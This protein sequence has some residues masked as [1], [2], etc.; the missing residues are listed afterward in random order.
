MLRLVRA[1]ALLL[2]AGTAR[3][4]DRPAV[5]V[6]DP[7]GEA[8]R[9]A[10]QRFGAVGE[11]RALAE[12]VRGE[13]V[14]GLEWSSL[15]QELSP[16]AFLAP[17]ETL[18]LDSGPA[19]ACPDWRQSGADALVE[20]EIRQ[21]AAEIEIEF[22]AWDIARCRKLL[23]KRYRGDP[24]DARRMSRSIADD[25]V[26]AFTGQRGVFG[27]EIAFV[28]TRAGAAEIFVMNADGTDL[29]PATRNRS[30]NAFPS[31]SPKGD[32]IVYMSY[33]YRR[34][35]HL[36]RLVRGPGEPG[37][38]L[39][40]L[41]SGRAQYRGVYAPDGGRLAVVLSVDG[42]PEIFTVG[43]DGGNLR[44]LTRHR[45]IDVSPTWSPDGRR[46]AFV[47]DRAGAPHVYVMDADGGNVRRLTFDGSYNA[48]PAW[49]PDGRWVAYQTRVGGQFDIW[50]IDPEGSVNAPLVTHP[51]SDESPSWSPDGR[52][53]VF[54]TVRR[55][56]SD[57]YVI[58]VTGHNLRRLTDERGADKSPAWGPYPR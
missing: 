50:L 34:Q 9:A 22:R 43:E 1:L 24:G 5:I 16:K 54:Q 35:P 4:E 45:A 47:S 42:A 57:L 46:I 39:P 37:L 36:F 26:E 25:V 20:G 48:A 31:W 27:T 10:V 56:R 3:A 18:A 41:N 11:G 32:A 58:D 6:T 51:R 30:L 44:R 13:I 49:S 7:G 2:V 12:R 21:G 15:F 53:L 23:R 55:G 19:V 40:R 38:L 8:Y 29:R 28:S 14:K 33:R 17:V 52:K